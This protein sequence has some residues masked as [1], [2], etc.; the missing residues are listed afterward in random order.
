MGGKGEKMTQKSAKK[1]KKRKKKKQTT[2][3]K[4]Q[5]KSQFIDPI[6]THFVL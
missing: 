3:P 1:E 6:T 4:V 2:N 5:N